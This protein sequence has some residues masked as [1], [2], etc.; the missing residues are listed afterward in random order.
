MLLFRH[1]EILLAKSLQ[2][3]DLLDERNRELKTLLESS[4]VADKEK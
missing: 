3:I 4:V 1:R 2:K